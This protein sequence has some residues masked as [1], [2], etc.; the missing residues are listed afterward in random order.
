[1]RSAQVYRWQI[2]MD[3]GVVLRDRRL[4]TR[5]GLYVCLRD[6]EREGWGEISPL[7]GFSQESWEEAQSALLTWVNGWLA[8]D[9]ALPEMPSVAFGVSCALAE[10]ADALPQ[11]ANYR[12]APLCNGD[13]DDLILK[14]ADMPGEKVAKVKVGL[15]EA[16]RDGMVVNLLLEAIP[17]LHL[18]LDANRAWTPLK[19]QQFA[20][21]V[22]P[23]YRDRI[24]F[25]EEPC[26]TRD[27]SRAF[28]RETGIAIAWDESLREPDFTFAAE[29]GVRAV[30]IKPTLTGSLDKVCE[31]VQA[32][33]A[34][35]LTA[36]ISSS[37]ESSLGLTQL[38]RIAAWLTPDTIPGLDTLDLMQAQQVRRWPGSPLPLVEVDALERLL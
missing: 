31:Q 25:L 6:G 15:Y 18:R 14:L 12:A 34:L 32:A 3:S 23:D 9:C 36:V 28:A 8:G 2:P 7:P 33:H 16:V 29:E 20:K 38:A 17:D 24:A 35:G 5:D 4:K 22:N 13:P 1:M 30:V 37:I 10:L 21:Y 11:A 19:G 27:D 26:K